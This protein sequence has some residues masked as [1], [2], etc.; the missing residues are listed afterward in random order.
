MINNSLPVLYKNKEEC[1]GC[2]ACYAICPNKA[3][4]MKTDEEG[5]EYPFIDDSKCVKCYACLRVCPLK[6][7]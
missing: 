3:I 2:S 1:C 6:N 7:N 4:S 5:F